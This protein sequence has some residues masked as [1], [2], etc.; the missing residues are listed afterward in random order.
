MSAVTIDGYLI[1]GFEDL[2]DLGDRDYND[3]NDL[4]I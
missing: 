3:G 1:I 4:R 2:Y